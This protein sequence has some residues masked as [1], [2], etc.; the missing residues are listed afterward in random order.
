ME[1][2]FEIIINELRQIKSL[3]L[4]QKTIF[5]L[6]E[7]V[8]YTGLSKSY[9]Y[10]LTSTNEIPYFKPNGKLIF[11]KKDEIDNWLLQNRNVTKDEIESIAL[12][13]NTLNRLPTN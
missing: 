6:D 9:L 1:K 13:Y 3:F 8:I 2:E 4:S 10:K 5:N 11:F 12:N 7:L